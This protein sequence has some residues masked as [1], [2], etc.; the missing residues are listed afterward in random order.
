[1]FISLLHTAAEIG[2]VL[3]LMHVLAIKLRDTALGSAIAFI[4]GTG[5]A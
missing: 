5:A 4:Y 3:A 1:M 2:I